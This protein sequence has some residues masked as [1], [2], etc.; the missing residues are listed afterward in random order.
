MY[1][2]GLEIEGIGLIG[3]P[4]L[5]AQAEKIIQ[6]FPSTKL[7]PSQFKLNHSFISTLKSIQTTVMIG[8]G[9]ARRNVSLEL[10]SLCLYGAGMGTPNVDS[11]QEVESKQPQQSRSFAKLFIF[12]PSVYE[13]GEIS[14]YFEEKTRKQSA[15]FAASN[16]SDLAW[17]SISEQAQFE[18]QPLKSGFRIALVYDVCL[19]DSGIRPRPMSSKTL[20]TLSQFFTTNT[21]TSLSILALFEVYRQPN[22]SFSK[23]KATD[24][25]T[26]SALR[27]I[28]KSNPDLFDAYFV[29]VTKAPSEQPGWGTGGIDQKYIIV[30][31]YDLLGNPV[32]FDEKAVVK[33]LFSDQVSISTVARVVV[34]PVKFRRHSLND[35]SVAVYKLWK[36][37]NTK[38]DLIEIVFFMC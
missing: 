5:S 24:L 15:D 16:K 4:L 34:W 38:T 28:Q 29:D 31:W 1:S 33:Q 6:L 8:L 13:G 25:R 12:L 19:N 36:G 23:L 37:T 35:N 27:T 10:D 30:R 3:F 14:V 17:I 18:M 26:I 2:P 22:P 7:V 20:T 21:F 11:K 9:V 32:A